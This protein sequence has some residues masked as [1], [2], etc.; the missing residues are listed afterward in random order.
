M[1]SE[2]LDTETGMMIHVRAVGRVFSVGSESAAGEKVEDFGGGEDE[3]DEAVGDD[4]NAKSAP[5][6]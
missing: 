1:P 3:P 2:V 5:D 4:E 6:D